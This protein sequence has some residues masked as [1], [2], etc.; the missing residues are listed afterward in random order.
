MGPTPPLPSIT[1]GAGGAAGPSTANLK[2]G[3]S[4]FDSSN[5]TVATGASR[6]SGFDSQL[7]IIIGA[8]GIAGL[9]AWKLIK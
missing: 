7:L 1:G 2:G 4:S 8:I 9:V 6:A 5:W 3:A